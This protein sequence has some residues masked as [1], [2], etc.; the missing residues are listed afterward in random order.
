MK[1]FELYI[2]EAK[3]E[4]KFCVEMLEKEKQAAKNRYIFKWECKANEPKIF[5]YSLIQNCFHITRLS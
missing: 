1:Q 3:E 2:S 5:D 4:V